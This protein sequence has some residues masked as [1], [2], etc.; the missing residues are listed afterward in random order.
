MLI[1]FTFYI[2][3]FLAAGFWEFI[4]PFQLK[5]NNSTIQ[6][7]RI[8]EN[9]TNDSYFNTTNLTDILNEN[10]SLF[11]IADNNTMSH[12]TWLFLNSVTEFL[13]VILLIFILFKKIKEMIRGKSLSS[14]ILVLLLHFFSVLLC[15]YIL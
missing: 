1:A 15:F 7:F 9:F 8:Y 14:Y 12:I 5:K 3:I 13:A 4:L 11:G 2:V 6:C 10:E